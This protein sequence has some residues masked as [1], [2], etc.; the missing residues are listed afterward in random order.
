[1]HVISYKAIREFQTLNPALYAKLLAEV[2]PHP[3]K[4]ALEYDRMVAEVGRCMK[5]GEENLTAEE[6][7][8]LE[9]MSILIEEYDRQHYSLPPCQ[10]HEMVAFLLEQR[11]L[12]PHDL[13]P[14][15]GSKSRVSEILAQSRAISKS[16]AKKLAEFFHVPI[17]LFI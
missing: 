7:S 6:N 1:M 16:Q 13:W 12:Q 9:M 3:I 11:G 17:H 15:L 8:L 5:R 10:P 2:Q 4:N 14:V